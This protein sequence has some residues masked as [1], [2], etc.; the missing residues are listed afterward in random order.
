MGPRPPQTQPADCHPQVIAEIKSR[1]VRGASGKH[2]ITFG[3]L[4]EET[5]NIFDALAGILKTGKKYGVVDFEGEQLWQGQ[6]DRS[7][8]TLLKEEHSGIQIRRRL[9]ANLRTPT[10][11][12]KRGGFG[13]SWEEGA[14]CAVCG[15]R[16][17]QAEW[18][19]VSGKSLHKG[20]F[21][22]HGTP[23]YSC[24]KRLTQTEYHVAADMKWRC[25]RCHDVTE[26][27]R[28]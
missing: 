14:A 24:S 2:E 11:G 6:N 19:G 27:A 18:V 5:D 16:I 23:E 12:S 9:K 1:G 10:P 28:F 3:Q 15:K 4:F 22:C 13:N 21:K 26:R 8:I 7:V 17:Y 25:K 20:C